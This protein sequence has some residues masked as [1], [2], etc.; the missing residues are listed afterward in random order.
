M[1][2]ASKPATLSWVEVDR[3]VSALV[4]ELRPYSFGSI[5]AIARSGLVPAVMLSHGLGVRELGVLDIRRTLNDGIDAPKQDPVLRGGLNTTALGN[6]TVLLV[7]DIVGS[8]STLLAARSELCQYSL[9]TATLVVN[10][11]NLGARPVSEIVDHHAAVVH[12]WVVF[13]W[14]AS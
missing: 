4:E 7:D 12:G 1:S 13:P 6:N 5:V 2:L 9:I 10:K 8:G 3:M 11:T 14:E